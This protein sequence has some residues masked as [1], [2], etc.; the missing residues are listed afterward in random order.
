VWRLPFADAV[1]SGP[2]WD[3]GWLAL[4]TRAGSIHVF[5]GEDGA[6]IWSRDLGSPAHAKPAIAAD[7]V[8][9]PTDDGRVVALQIESGEP[10]WERKLGGAADEILALEDRLYVGSKDNH[11][12]CLFAK[13]GQVDWRWRTGGDVV[14]APIVE[15]RRVY[16]VAFDNMLRALD[17]QSGVQQWIRPL[18]LRP[19]T[20]PVRAGGTIVV[21]G[22]VPPL[23]GYNLKDGTP[24]GEIQATAEIGAPP[25]VFENPK[26]P[27]PFLLFV[28]RDI[29]K[30]ASATLVTRSFEPEIAPVSPLPNVITFETPKPSPEADARALTPRSR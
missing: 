28:V 7:R 20:G 30:G 12:Y 14:G 5:R 1:A 17:R 26:S 18:P 4:S 21:S 15:E 11:L 13:D 19:T 23:R 29:A 16:F 24:A 2:V 3:N 10:L 27:A 9:V 8:Y 22:L 25:H 6:P